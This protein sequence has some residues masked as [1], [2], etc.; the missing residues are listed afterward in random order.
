MQYFKEFIETDLILLS[1][2]LVM[3]SLAYFTI[4][5]LDNKLSAINHIIRD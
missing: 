4:N 1:A 2:E 3:V 5:Y